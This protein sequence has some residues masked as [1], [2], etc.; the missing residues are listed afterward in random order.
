MI[1]LVGGMKDTVDSSTNRQLRMNETIS[2]I[3][4]TRL[5]Q[6]VDEETNILL[7]AWEEKGKLNIS[8]EL[9]YEWW[10]QIVHHEVVECPSLGETRK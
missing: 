8:W 1:S 9:L 3:P 5:R 7:D 6:L 4:L 10:V 2:T